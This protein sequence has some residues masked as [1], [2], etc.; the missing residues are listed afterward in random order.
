MISALSHKAELLNAN[1]L[2]EYSQSLR[3]FNEYSGTV[4]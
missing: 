4:G 1:P 3:T 2:K